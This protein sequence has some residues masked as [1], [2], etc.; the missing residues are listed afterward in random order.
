MVDAAG[1][2]PGLLWLDPCVGS[3]VFLEALH[4]K[5][6]E[7]HQIVAVDLDPTP[8]VR[9]EIARTFRGFD[10]LRWAQ[11]TTDRFDRIVANPPYVPL[12]RLESP[13]REQAL[14]CNHS[15]LPQLTL[16]SNYW[17][18]FIYASL[19]VL[20]PGGS[21]CFVLPSSWDHSDYGALLRS[22][23]P[24]LFERF[25][26]YRSWE[27]LFPPVQEG[28][29]VIVGHGYGFTL[30]CSDILRMEYRTAK[31]LILALSCDGVPKSES[32][33]IS[34]S[35]ISKAI[36]QQSRYR[37]GDVLAIRLGGVTGDARF[38]LLPDTQRRE[39]HI[40]ED[41]CRP[42]LS[43]ARHLKTGSVGLVEWNELRDSGD[44]AWLFRP[45]GEWTEHPAVKEYLRFGEYDGGCR[46]DR[47]KIRHRKPWFQTPMPT[48]VDGFISGMSR[49]GPW[50][51]LN[52]EP[53]LGATNTLYVVRFKKSLSLDEKAAWAL[54]FL[55][56][57]T[58][59]HLSKIARIYPGGL[60]KFEPGDLL[61]LPLAEPVRIDG[62]F[63]KYQEAFVA[64][65]SQGVEAG[66]DIAD[67]WLT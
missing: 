30:G 10:F 3:G 29:V 7:S 45:E 5:G 11:F 54:S 43:R 52:T 2:S 47:Y 58:E 13:L 40:P 53:D 41:A 35:R 28:C 36:H 50:I 25:I 39:R 27:P 66:R 31:E 34:H 15:M 38:F 17:C 51:V 33:S 48:D 21:L 67:S 22:T 64:V 60:V 44:R 37:V 9:D 19:T 32:P 49:H 57:S 63:E 56:S 23:L 6:V 59:S 46:C 12:G 4:S 1:L 42:V 61:L 55:S 62:A 18:A 14:L 8:R 16:G 24:R 26:V 65:Q 20:R